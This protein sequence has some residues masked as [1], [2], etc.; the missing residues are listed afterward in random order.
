[1][2]TLATAF[3]ADARPSGWNASDV[4]ESGAFKVSTLQVEGEIHGYA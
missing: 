3:V 4:I 2:F 1:M